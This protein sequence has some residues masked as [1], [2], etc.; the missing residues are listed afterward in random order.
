QQAQPV[1]ARRERGLRGLRGDPRPRRVEGV[2]V[3]A[4]ALV[5]ARRRRTALTGAANR[6][7]LDDLW[8]LRGH[9]SPAHVRSARISSN[10]S[11]YA[12]PATAPQRRAVARSASAERG[13]GNARASTASRA[14]QAS[15]TSIVSLTSSNTPG[16]N[17]GSSLWNA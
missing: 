15:L 17:A 11:A 8:S 13:C 14:M 12:M 4:E 2:V 10:A 3:A 5:E 6:W 16:R 1:A 9:V 7:E